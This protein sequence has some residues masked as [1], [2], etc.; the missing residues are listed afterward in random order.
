MFS[1]PAPTYFACGY[2]MGIYFSFEDLL[3][4]LNPEKGEGRPSCGTDGFACG[5]GR[6]VGGRP[7]FQEMG[8]RVSITDEF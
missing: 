3:K 2:L 4:N 1:C 5:P 8:L 6:G 7:S